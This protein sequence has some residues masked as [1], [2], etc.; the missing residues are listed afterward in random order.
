MSEAKVFPIDTDSL[1]KGSVISTQE[2]ESIFDVKQSDAAFNL[3]ALKLKTYITERFKERGEVVTVACENS[4]LK[5]LT[6]PEASEYNYRRVKAGVSQ[7]AGAHQR[8]M[9]VDVTGL[10]PPQAA[11]H[12]KHIIRTGMVL[13]SIQEAFKAPLITNERTTPKLL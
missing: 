11:Q 5:I 10:E 8:N 1:Q 4:T 9:G 3:A 13:M 7:I 6:D 2:I 12:E